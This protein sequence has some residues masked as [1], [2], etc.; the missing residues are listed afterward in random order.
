MSDLGAIFH[1]TADGKQY[2]AHAYTTLDECPEPNLKIKFKG[3]PAYIKLEAKGSG[4]V[5]CY[6]RNKAGN[7]FQVKKEGSVTPFFTV[8]AESNEAT[9]KADN[10]KYTFYSCGFGHPYSPDSD[11]TFIGSIT[12]QE[13]DGFKILALQDQGYSEIDVTS[14][15]GFNHTT[16]YAAANRKCILHIKGNDYKLTEFQFEDNFFYNEGT[17]SAIGIKDKEQITV[18]YT[19]L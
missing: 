3:S 12:P 17:G 14:G 16:F 4:D 7:I 18:T 11:T 10:K 8:T 1:V 15:D 19:L 6:V 9:V 5:P 2:D 13:I